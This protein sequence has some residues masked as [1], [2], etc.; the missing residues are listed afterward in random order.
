M[1][2][3][4]ILRVPGPAA[5]NWG[6]QNLFMEPIFSPIT[7]LAALRLLGPGSQSW[8]TRH[9]VAQ[10]M[11][12]TRRRGL[13][14]NTCL[15]SG[16]S[17]FPGRLSLGRLPGVGRLSGEWPQ[18]SQALLVLTCHTRLA[19]EQHGEWGQCDW[20]SPC[21][22]AIREALALARSWQTVCSNPD[23]V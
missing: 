15:S 7:G 8:V 21:L 12:S 3:L 1:A 19:G 9:L 13:L 20:E 6:L 22:T 2:F 18:S 10:G 23:L 17:G 16:K 14:S 4:S 5:V 11:R